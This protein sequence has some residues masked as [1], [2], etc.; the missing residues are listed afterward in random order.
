MSIS[1]NPSRSHLLNCQYNTCWLARENV[2]LLLCECDTCDTWSENFTP[3]CS[4]DRSRGVSSPVGRSVRHGNHGNELSSDNKRKREAPP[5]D[6]TF[7][8][9]WASYLLSYLLFKFDHFIWSCLPSQSFRY[10]IKRVNNSMGCL[11]IIVMKLINL[12]KYL[13]LTDYNKL[14]C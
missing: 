6:V 8:G 12:F 4:G 14:C 10:E 9:L 1:V 7:N 2:V 3:G 5:P 13:T 11:L